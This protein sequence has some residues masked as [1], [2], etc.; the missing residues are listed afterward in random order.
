M[1]SSFR[2][3]ISGPYA[4]FTRP[5]MKVERVSYDVI[6]PSAARGILEAILWK[7]QMRWIVERIE[8]LNP[9]HFVS[10]RRNEVGARA[11]APDAAHIEGRKPP[12]S[13]DATHPSVRQQRA[14]LL[15]RDVAY[16][17]QARTTLTERA[18]PQDTLGKY[19]DMF[20]RRAERGQWAR[21]P[22]LGCREFAADVSLADAATPAPLALD[23][24]LG[25][26]LL[27]LVWEGT[28]A[29]PRFFHAE[30]RRG[31]IEVPELNG[32]G[33]VA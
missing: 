4:C 11:T 33:V 8:V 10:M 29:S 7:P 24:D 6:T 19:R 17:V 25:W 9:I 2:I 5:E 12:P 21:P 30:M 1:D 14:S 20:L 27:D 16:V 22:C 26:M 32:A 3:H 31:V 23:R 13:L 18:G 28:R 15:L